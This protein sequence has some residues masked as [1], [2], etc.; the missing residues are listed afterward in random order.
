MRKSE[1]CISSNYVLKSYVFGLYF[2]SLNLSIILARSI[3]KYRNEMECP[4]QK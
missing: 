2:E 4:S 3:S 1:M